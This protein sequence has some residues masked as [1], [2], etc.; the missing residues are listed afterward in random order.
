[1]TV[2]L[3]CG[4]RD[5]SDVSRVCDELSA[6][7]VTAVVHGGAKGADSIAGDWAREN[8]IAE[9]VVNPQWAFYNKAAGSVRNGW[10][11]E[12]VRVDE[13]LAFKGGNGTAD[14]VKQARI[15][16]VRVTEVK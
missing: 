6:R 8:G 2:Y 14:M 16:G 10:M 1:M 9:V 4:G 15:A 7:S 5:F 12:F 13:V 3:V 11:L